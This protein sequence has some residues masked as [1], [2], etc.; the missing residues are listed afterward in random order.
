M[1]FDLKNDKYTIPTKSSNAFGCWT[2]VTVHSEHGQIH[3]KQ[4]LYTTE[5]RRHS[6]YLDIGLKSIQE[7]VD[8]I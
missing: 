6:H 3:W 1:G 4:L 2:T 5:F 8:A 7:L